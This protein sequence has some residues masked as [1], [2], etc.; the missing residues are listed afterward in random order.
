MAAAVDEW[1]QLH[2]RILAA[3]GEDCKAAGELVRSGKLSEAAFAR[4]RVTEKTIRE[5]VQRLKEVTRLEEGFAQLHGC[6]Y[7]VG[8]SNGTDAITLALKAL[9]IGPGAEVIIP[10]MT[11]FATASGLM[12]DS[13]RSTAIHWAPA[14]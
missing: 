12:I 6:Q 11:F 4:L 2:A 1:D 13:V 14:R 8:V 3:N 5:M 10:A 9:N 7:A